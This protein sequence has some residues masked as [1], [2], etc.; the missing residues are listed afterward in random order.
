MVTSCFQINTRVRLDG[1]EH[2]FHRLVQGCIWQ[3]EK[4]STGEII[5]KE[6]QVLLRM[7]EEGRLA[8]LPNGNVVL[9]R[10]LSANVLSEEFEQAKL[11]RLYVKGVQRLPKTKAA[12]E[13]AIKNTW[14][15][16]KDPARPPS[17]ST[18]YRWL[19]RFENADEDIR[20]LVDNT[21]AKGNRNPRCQPEIERVC[22]ETIQS[23]YLRRERPNIHQTL[24]NAR[25]RVQQQNDHRPKA[26]QL[27]PP[28]R[29]LLTR[30]IKRLPAF[31]RHAA[32]H[33]YESARVV[34]RSVKGHRVTEKPLERA[35][36]DHTLLDVVLVDHET[37]QPT[38]RPWL[39]LCIDDHSRCV[40][41]FELGFDSPSFR[42]VAACLKQCFTPKA[43]LKETYPRLNSEWHA[44][45]VM[46]ELALDN[47]R[48]F[49]SKSA[50]NVLLRLGIEAHFAPIKTGAYKGK[51]ERIFRTIQEEIMHTMPGTTFRNTLEKGDYNPDKH[52]C[53]SLPELAEILT[54]WIVE[55]YHQ[56]VHST[57]QR[58]PNQVWLSGI[59]PDEIRYVD[60]LT[61]LDAI[62]G[63]TYKRKLTHK[64]IEWK[65]LSYNSDELQKLRQLKGEKLE[66]ELRI[67][68]TNIGC[69][70]VFLPGLEKPIRVPALKRD[71]ADG[72]SLTQH[73]VYTRHDREQSRDAGRESGVLYSKALVDELLQAARGK[74]GRLG[75][76]AATHLEQ[77]ARNAGRETNARTASA[78]NIVGSKP[79]SLAPASTQPVP[80]AI[81]QEMPI[82][83]RARP[84]L[85][86]I[87]REDINEQ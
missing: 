79:E 71:Y 77:R 74:R 83:L 64:G 86:A 70:Y 67:D 84:R 82:G 10:P 81:R 76:R 73:K 87:K 5:Q 85:A 59:D 38:A 44:A 31:D 32:R 35:E 6:R 8:F 30:M 45:G 52:A 43:K 27:E 11:R 53:V 17:F 21:A 19:T 78:K 25:I 9:V 34:F 63:A 61:E 33:G 68:E 24:E 23:F 29:R 65:G 14:N 80:V 40:L 4:E 51:V 41:G 39:T 18:V 7:L 2:R 16:I 47:G 57:L 36:I 69:G 22:D 54:I 26:H 75:R 28:S 50:E 15:E 56:R 37:R 60:D 66:V 20:A 49:H 62:L 42:T 55:N 72:I 12:F 48:D 3:L 1:T 58:T 13:Q 46:R